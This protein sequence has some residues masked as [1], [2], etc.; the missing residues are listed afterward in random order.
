MVVTKKRGRP[1]KGRSTL[2]PGEVP[3]ASNNLEELDDFEYEMH[4][5]EYEI[6]AHVDDDDPDYEP[7]PKKRDLKVVVPKEMPVEIP[8]VALT[9]LAKMPSHNPSLN[10][11]VSSHPP[12]QSPSTPKPESPSP[13]NPQSP[14][15]YHLQSPSPPKTPSPS[16]PKTQ[17]SSGPKPQMSSGPRPK[18]MPRPPGSSISR[19][20]G[21]PKPRPQGPPN[22][23][24]QGP[25]KPRPQGP[26]RP[27]PQGPMNSRPQ[28]P[29]NS[30]GKPA[31][32]PLTKPKVVMVRKP[33]GS[34]DP[35][36][37]PSRPLPDD[38]K[39]PFL[40]LQ[41]SGFNMLK[42]ELS[43]FRDS[44]MSLNTR[45]NHLELALRPV[46]HIADSLSRIANAVERLTCPPDDN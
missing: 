43:G 28:G 44:V 36:R 41:Q 9:D 19:P 21:P 1:P 25:P 2:E 35:N 6:P 42:K 37:P 38:D 40:E 12:A 16:L 15:L 5:F 14:S 23:T 24:P 13:P 8:V 31:G 18:M 7:S 32:A 3:E 45:L 11:Q 22:S 26:P 30:S 17:A 10:P 46:G 33:V 29:P 34:T 39:H 4:D 27:R 20:Q